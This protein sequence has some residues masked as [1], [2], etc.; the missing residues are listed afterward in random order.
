MI[1]EKLVFPGEINIKDIILV[2]FDRSTFVSLQDYLIELNITES[3]F[4]SVVSGTIMLSDSRNLIQE[5]KI[6]G[7]EYLYIDVRTPTLEEK[8]GISKLYK[9]YG[10]DDKQYVNDGA[11][12][13]YKLNF[14]STE[15][16]NDLANPIY[17]A[18]E[19]KPEEVVQQIFFEYLQAD[20][21]LSVGKDTPKE[22][23]SP[24]TIMNDSDNVIKFVSPGWNPLQCINWIA[25]KSLPETNKA[26]N[27]LF[28]ETTKGFYFGSTDK[29][30]SNLDK[31]QNGTYVYSESF[32][33]TLGPDEKSKSMYAIKSLTIDKTLDQLDNTRT[34][35]LASTVIDVDLY[36]KKYK[37]VFYD[38]S[39]KFSGYSHLHESETVP[40]FDINTLRNPLG[41][42]EVNFSTP[43]LHNKIENNFDEIV[44]SVRGNRR[45]TMLELN[46]FK[47]QLVVPGR[48]DLEAGNII[49]II[50][51]KNSPGALTEK[52]K[53]N[54]KYDMLYSGYYLITNLSHKINP[55]T[56]Y[57][58]MNVVK[59]S[60]SKSEYYKV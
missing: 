45:S 21:G 29:I 20:R 39:D 54:R 47:M 51:P 35:Y 41:Y 40:L 58:T 36:R 13:I 33:N 14:S 32:I 48:T 56:H 55:K 34:G 52:D 24:I 17:R 38:H 25:S 50:F 9:I 12:L 43:K 8:Y 6:D 15:Q 19:G 10:L 4:S 23:K 37:N 27:F 60:F 46:N 16:F 3:L 53:S 59:D 42:I 49:Q 26:A 18:F 28:W 57:I 22:N 2:S 30:F 7:S 31:M 5:L 1:D 44:K 11:T